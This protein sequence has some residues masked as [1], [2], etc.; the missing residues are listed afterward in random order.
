MR[1]LL[2]IG[3]GALAIAAFAHTKPSQAYYGGAWCAKI[4]QGGGSVGEFVMQRPA[5]GGQTKHGQYQNAGKHHQH[6]R[7]RRTHRHHESDGH[8]GG[9]A[10][11]QHVP[12]EH[13]LQCVDGVGGGRDS[14]RQRSGHALGEIAWRV[15]G[16][17]T[18]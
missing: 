8:D 17:M 12:N 18:K 5:G 14:A 11:R 10:G 16:E 7:H 15:S 13:V 4:D 9:H 1:K 2:M 3:A 6:G